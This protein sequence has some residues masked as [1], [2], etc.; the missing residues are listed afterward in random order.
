[1][2]D[3]DSPEQFM[4][5]RMRS[6]DRRRF[7][8]P[9]STSQ[10]VDFTARIYQRLAWR[11]VRLSA[12]STA[13][14]FISLL[15]F[16]AFIWPGLMQ[17]D[18]PD[19]LRKQFDE[20]LFVV[21]IGIFVG[22]PVAIIAMAHTIGLTMRAVADYVLEQ[23]VD[24]ETASKTAVTGVRTMFV[25]LIHVFLRSGV[26]V[27]AAGALFMVSAYAESTGL[28]ILAEILTVFAFIGLIACV[29]VVPFVFG[30][31]SMAPAVAAIEGVEPKRA[32]KRGALLIKKA[33]HIA[34][35][36]DALTHV[37]VIGIFCS[38][39]LWGGTYLVLYEAGLMDVL[40]D[41]GGKSVVWSLIA[42]TVGA[43]PGLLTIALIVPYLACG[44]TVIYFDRRVKLEAL[45]IETMAHD[46]IHGTET[47][48]LRS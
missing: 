7:L 11:L 31:L 27:V 29:I 41:L 32:L 17:T 8:T 39:L 25:L 23:N 47:A 4:Q 34:S 10:I 43:L 28:N 14:L 48:D 15:F 33:R 6:V 45:D 42:E 35:G 2:I 20:V 40:H 1:M 44:M 16:Q 12:P 18:A 19:D 9:R 3:L 21:G 5:R 37:W 30:S 46:V 24:F 22:L 26:Y 38:A 13:L 36:Y